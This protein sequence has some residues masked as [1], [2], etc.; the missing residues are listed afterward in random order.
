MKADVQNKLTNA[1]SM[2]SPI[3]VEHNSSP[4]ESP[5]TSP[6]KGFKLSLKTFGDKANIALIRAKHQIIQDEID[7]RLNLP[8]I[9]KQIKERRNRKSKSVMMND[10]YSLPSPSV[11]RENRKF[12]K[13]IT[14][15]PD[16][17]MYNKKQISQVI[18]D[19][20]NR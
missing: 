4:A 6:S 13:D 20:I 15:V 5:L 1:L 16:N 12:F 3:K 17:V 18:R 10:P 8:G 19:N 11:Y 2:A 14:F 9:I 7:Q